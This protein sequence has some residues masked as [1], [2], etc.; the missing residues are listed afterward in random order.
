LLRKRAT[1]PLLIDPLAHVANDPFHRD[2]LAVLI[3]DKG[4]APPA[5]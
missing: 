5:L 1:L 4:R 3:A 2:Q